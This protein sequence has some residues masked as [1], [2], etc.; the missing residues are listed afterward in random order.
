MIDN[1]FAY[2]KNPLATRAARPRGIHHLTTE[3]Y[4]PRT[5]GKVDR[6]HQTMV[7]RGPTSRDTKL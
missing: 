1:A 2:V 6:F 3:P 7:S 5:N 4:R